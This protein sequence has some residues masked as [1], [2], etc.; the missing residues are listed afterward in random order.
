MK[1]T[2]TI[3]KFTVKG[4]MAMIVLFLISK[5]IFAGLSTSCPEAPK[6]VFETDRLQLPH[7]VFSGNIK[8]SV[9]KFAASRTKKSNILAE[10]DLV[11]AQIEP[12]APVCA[13][14]SKVAFYNSLYSLPVVFHFTSRGP[15]VTNA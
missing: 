4:L 12:H 2:N 5:Y 10:A 14:A 1:G 13:V 15:P 11:V 7:V 3:R 6:P 9:L 8:K